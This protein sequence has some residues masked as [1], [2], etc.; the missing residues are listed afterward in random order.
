MTR[1]IVYAAMVPSA[2]DG[3]V[4][5]PSAISELAQL[6]PKHYSQELAL[7]G[8]LGHR[9]AAGA[10]LLRRGQVQMAQVRKRDSQSHCSP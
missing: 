4:D 9:C 3:V 7:H 6:H 2:L 1:R 8:L 10:H 5:I